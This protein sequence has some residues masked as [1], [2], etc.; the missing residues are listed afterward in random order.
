MA[1]KKKPA[2]KKKTAPKKKTVK[3]VKPAR[4]VRVQKK[5]QKKKQTEKKT[6][7]KKPK[8]ILKPAKK[9]VQ[10]KVKR[11]ASKTRPKVKKTEPKKKRASGAVKT[12]AKKVSQRPARKSSAAKAVHESQRRETLRRQLIQKRE[13]IVREAKSEIAKYISG[14]AN[15]L[16]ETALDEGD[17]SVIDVS[18]DI[19]LRRLGTH[20]QRLLGIDEALM[21]LREGTYGV[22]EECGAEISAE[23]LKVMP[24]AIFCRDCQ[25]KR[26]QLEKVEGE[27]IIT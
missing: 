1:T 19:N 17:W 4:K 6:L 25:E 26:E 27:A 12:R 13:E 21:K 11:P 15:Q 16:V 7:R 5:V 8:K 18:A 2:T 9:S 10:K 14:E 20:R 23:R 3:T 24:F 22:C